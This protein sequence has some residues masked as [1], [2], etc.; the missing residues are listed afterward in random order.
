MRDPH[1]PSSGRSRLVYSFRNLSGHLLGAQDPLRAPAHPELTIQGASDPGLDLW[2]PN[3]GSSRVR[4]S[5][6]KA[7]SPGLMVLYCQRNR[8][9]FGGEWGWGEGRQ[10]HCTQVGDGGKR[11]RVPAGGSGLPG[12][13]SWAVAV[14]SSPLCC[15]QLLRRL[16]ETSFAQTLPGQSGGF[17]SALRTPVGVGPIYGA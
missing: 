7:I 3:T 10:G 14:V 2:G 16:S 8:D 1:A 15:L 5:E 13:H 17:G 12:T 11:Q 6:A 9:G 4:K